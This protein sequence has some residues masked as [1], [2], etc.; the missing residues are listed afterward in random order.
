[1]DKFGILFANAIM[2]NDC[3]ATPPL[4]LTPL[5]QAHCEIPCGIYSDDTVFTDLH[6]HQATI[7]KSMVQITELSKDASAN[8]KLSQTRKA[9]FSKLANFT[10]SLF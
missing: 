8:A 4:A 10:K 6:T 9:T 7:E 5:A 2:L 3:A 1:M